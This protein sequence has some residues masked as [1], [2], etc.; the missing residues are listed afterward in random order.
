MNLGHFCELA[1]ENRGSFMVWS[2]F[3]C[4][5]WGIRF[6]FLTAFGS[7]ACFRMVCRYGNSCPNQNRRGLHNR[8]N[9][10]QLPVRRLLFLM[11]WSM[12]GA[13]S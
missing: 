4:P 7:N 2:R 6:I 1:K 10:N 8:L 5:I 13:I 9:I 12:I 11:R 3:S